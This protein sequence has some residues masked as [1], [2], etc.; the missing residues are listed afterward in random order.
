[1]INQT[2]TKMSGNEIIYNTEVLKSNLCDFNNASILVKGDI[3]IIRHQVTHSKIVHDSLN[4]LRKL[5][6][7]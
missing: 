3:T 7:Q 5:M 1:M 2:K 4:V 6:G